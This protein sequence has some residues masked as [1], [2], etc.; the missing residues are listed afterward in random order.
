MTVKELT[1]LLRAYGNDTEVR[2]ETE[3]D[4]LVYAVPFSV[5]YDNTVDCVIISL[6]P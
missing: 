1:N 4:P 5:E 3:K 6:E 2:V